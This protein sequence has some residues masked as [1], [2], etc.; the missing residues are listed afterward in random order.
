MSLNLSNLIHNLNSIEKHALNGA[1]NDANLIFSAEP[2]QKV[3]LEKAV[4]FFKSEKVKAKGKLKKVFAAFQKTPNLKHALDVHFAIKI[5]G[6][7]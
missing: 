3:A 2:N 7:N 4:K 6:S 1:V 5:T